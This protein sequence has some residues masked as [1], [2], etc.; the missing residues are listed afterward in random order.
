[1]KYTAILAVNWAEEGLHYTSVRIKRI[2]MLDRE[3]VADMLE[4]ENIADTIRYLFH[5]WPK[6]QDV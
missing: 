2:K 6:M 4:R 5:G 3:T 1:M